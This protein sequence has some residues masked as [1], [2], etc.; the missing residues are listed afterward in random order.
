MLINI[1]LINYCHLILLKEH[2][3]NV[4]N[5]HSIHSSLDYVGHFNFKF[6]PFSVSVDLGTLLSPI[7]GEVEAPWLD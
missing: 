5:F 4:L 6:S 3:R 7:G 1:C 2:S